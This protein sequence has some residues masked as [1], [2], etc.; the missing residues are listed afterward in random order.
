[1]DKKLKFGVVG[2]GAR[3]SGLLNTL[4]RVEKAEIVAVCDTYEDRVDKAIERIREERNGCGIYGLHENVR[5]RERGSGFNRKLVG[6]TYP[7]GN[8]E[9]ACGKDNRL[10][11]RRRVRRGRVLGT[12][13]HVRRNENAD[14]VF[15]KLLFR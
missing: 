2:L 13:P 10:R 12:R 14:Y 9:Y 5:G 7:Y 1:M 3:G 11:G 6:R 4:M 8:T 15:G